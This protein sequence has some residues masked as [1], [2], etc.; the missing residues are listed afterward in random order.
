L[1]KIVNHYEKIIDISDQLL[2]AV[3]SYTFDCFADMLAELELK[4]ED[5]TEDSY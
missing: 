4:K 2:Q 5:E 1:G 3:I